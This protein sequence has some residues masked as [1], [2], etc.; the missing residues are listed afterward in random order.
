M[1]FSKKKD[2]INTKG[3]LCCK[4]LKKVELKEFNY[5]KYIR[6]ITYYNICNNC[7]NDIINDKS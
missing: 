7:I 6:G 2:K 3:E 5:I 1:I 4:C